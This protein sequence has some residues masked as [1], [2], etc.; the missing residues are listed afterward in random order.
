[1]RAMSTGIR[2][3]A[4]Q[5]LRD[6]EASIRGLI[7]DAAGD[8]RYDDIEWLLQLGRRLAALAAP[9][10]ARSVESAPAPRN[11][12]QAKGEKTKVA[13]SGQKAARK[14]PIYST[15]EERLIKIGWSK[16]NRAEYEHRAPKASIQIISE[17]IKAK[18]NKAGDAFEAESL[19]P[20]LTE[21]GQEVPAYQ[22]YM[23]I[24]WLRDLG[25]LKKDGRNKYRLKDD[26]LPFD[27]CW[28]RA[29]SVA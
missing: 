17:A 4:E 20:L 1:M 2:E 25:A 22:V 6:A 7:S 18:R 13:R 24:G 19:M 8:Q 15:T 9:H 14:Y 21:D 5:I 11:I 26:S 23:A 28:D 29:R 10:A 16:K 12:N 27:A 3:K